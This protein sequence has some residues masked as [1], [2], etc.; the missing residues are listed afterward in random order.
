MGTSI[1][2]YFIICA[3][4]GQLIYGHMFNR[5]YLQGFSCVHMFSHACVWKHRLGSLSLFTHVLHSSRRLDFVNGIFIHDYIHVHRYL[6]LL[7]VHAPIS[8]N[9]Q[10][11]VVRFNE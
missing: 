3:H 9:M 8:M 5:A 2:A 1:K 7:L 11:H 6:Y 4:I 10:Y